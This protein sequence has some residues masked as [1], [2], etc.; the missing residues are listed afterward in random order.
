[1]LPPSLLR[2]FRRFVS[3]SNLSRPRP[4][5]LNMTSDPVRPLLRH[6]HSSPA[7]TTTARTSPPQYE[8]AYP[9]IGTSTA[10]QYHSRASSPTLGSVSMPDETA[11]MVSHSI[12]SLSSMTARSK[13]ASQNSLTTLVPRQTP[14]LRAVSLGTLHH[15]E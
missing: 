7:S 11:A 6:T 9:S 8:P 1:M 10:S 5:P 3:S 13:N 14:L 15:H 12:A 2:P 4:P